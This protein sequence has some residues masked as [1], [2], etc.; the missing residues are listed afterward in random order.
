MARYDSQGRP[1][2]FV[3]TGGKVSGYKATRR[4]ADTAGFQSARPYL[5][6]WAMTVIDFVKI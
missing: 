2:G 4:A 6:I 3:L 1:L 5:P